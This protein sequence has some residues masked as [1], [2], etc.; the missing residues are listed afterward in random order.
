MLD[1]L[2][3]GPS[4]SSKFN[5]LRRKVEKEQRVLGSKRDATSVLM[6]SS[7]KLIVYP[8]EHDNGELWEVD[9]FEISLKQKDLCSKEKIISMIERIYLF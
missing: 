9:S 2:E 8:K 4:Y 5:G 7:R 3:L 6:G 1:E